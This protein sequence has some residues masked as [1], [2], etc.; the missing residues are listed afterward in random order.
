MAT[1]ITGYN[2]KK[3]TEKTGLTPRQI[4]F[5]SE[6]GVVTPEVDLGEGRGKARV[7]SEHNMIQFL[8]IKNLADLGMPI[9]K[10]KPFL[11][12]IE[13]HPIIKQYEAS[14]NKNTTGG[15]IKLFIADGK[16]P[17][18]WAITSDESEAQNILNAAEMVNYNECIVIN[19]GRIVRGK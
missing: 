18:D 2:Q 12:Y 9:S 5:Y 19:F 1:K 6:Q 15:Y 8:I 16:L 7:Y 14:A 11:R 4:Q 17:V 13:Q 10:I 3:I